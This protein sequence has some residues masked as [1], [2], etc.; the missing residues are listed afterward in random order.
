MADPKLHVRN[1]SVRVPGH[2]HATG[3]RIAAG[4]RDTLAATPVTAPR[5]LGALRLRIQV[6]HGAT[7]TE[8]L[9]AIQRAL[10][11]ALAQE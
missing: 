3:D 6:G 2:D 10:A 7:E 8:T 9:H 4:I 1:L 11:E 5:S